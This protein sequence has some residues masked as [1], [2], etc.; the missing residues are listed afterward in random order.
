VIMRYS[1]DGQDRM[2]DDEDNA[3]AHASG[4]MSL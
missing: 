1:D 4:G 3:E 2:R